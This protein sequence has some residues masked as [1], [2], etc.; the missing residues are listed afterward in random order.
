MQNNETIFP[1]VAETGRTMVSVE[2]SRRGR[3]RHYVEIEEALYFDLCKYARAMGE[4]PLEY[5]ERLILADLYPPCSPAIS[6][7][8]HGQHRRVQP[9]QWQTRR[10][11]GLDQAGSPLTSGLPRLTM[12]LRSSDF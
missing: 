12:I 5:I 10:V 6:E 7:T 1:G 3:F 8:G 9:G 4:E 2:L 11:E